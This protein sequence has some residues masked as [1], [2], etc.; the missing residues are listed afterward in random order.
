MFML[1]A[2]VHAPG[3]FVD[4]ASGLIWRVH[5]TSISPRH[6]SSACTN[7][8]QS[9]RWLPLWVGREKAIRQN[10][11][12]DNRLLMAGQVQRI[13]SAGAHSG[14][15]PGVGM[16]SNARGV[17]HRP[18]GGCGCLLARLIRGCFDESC[19]FFEHVLDA[20]HLTK[21]CRARRPLYSVP[22]PAERLSTGQ[23]EPI[24][25]CAS[26]DRNAP[27]ASSMCA[28]HESARRPQ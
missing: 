10:R 28:V 3:V 2:I 26:C 23:G 14:A 27:K 8:C 9:G 19:Y 7:A 1:P 6:C 20:T 24:V 11:R 13:A 5:G 22:L 25:G 12:A 15:K 16:R 4:D 21:T 18:L 17:V